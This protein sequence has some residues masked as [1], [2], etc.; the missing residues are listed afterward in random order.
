MAALCQY[1]C[2]A[3]EY[4]GIDLLDFEPHANK[5]GICLFRNEC[6]GLKMSREAKALVGFTAVYQ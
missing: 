4:T 5:N 2:K 3:T 1:Q 6:L